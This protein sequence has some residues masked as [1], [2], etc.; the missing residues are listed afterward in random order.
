MTTEA[1]FSSMVRSGRATNFIDVNEAKNGR[2][3]L[4]VTENT[5][6]VSDKK[7]RTTIRVYRESIDQ[8]L[9]ALSEATQTL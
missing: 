4:A 8:F 3:Y 9:Q 5:L 1:I 6:D 7:A 2:K